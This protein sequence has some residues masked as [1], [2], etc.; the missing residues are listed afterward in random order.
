MSE[1]QPV[2]VMNQYT[3]GNEQN[4][5]ILAQS[6]LAYVGLAAAEFDPAALMLTDMP[7]TGL[8]IVRVAEQ[9]EKIADALT[10]RCGIGLPDRLG[11]AV[12]GHYCMRWMS[13]DQWLLSCPLDEAYAIEQLLR[14]SSTGHKAIVNV[15]GGYCLLELSGNEALAV[16]MKSTG[17]NVHPDH[18]PPGKVVNTQFAKTQLTLR[19]VATNHYELIVRRSFADYLWLWLQRAGK[20]YGITARSV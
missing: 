15:S 1:K 12:N 20:E 6:G 17:Y 11:S 9:P 16:L 18:F 8:L 14:E 13:P 10:L 19:C 5:Q 2:A 4:G 7:V 3:Q